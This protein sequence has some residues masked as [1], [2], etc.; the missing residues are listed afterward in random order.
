MY[1]VTLY[2]S[3][4]DYEQRELSWILGLLKWRFWVEQTRDFLCKKVCWFG[5][6][7]KRTQGFLCMVVVVAELE[8]RNSLD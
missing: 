3:L 1:G 8:E 6:N 2:L 7:L 5:L 4:G